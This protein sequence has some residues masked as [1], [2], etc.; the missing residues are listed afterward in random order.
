MDIILKDIEQKLKNTLH[1]SG[2]MFHI[3]SRVKSL[4]STTNKLER[5]KEVYKKEGKKMQDYLALRITLYFNDDIE[6]IHKYLKN[7]ANFVDESIDITE[8]DKFCPKRLNII[9]RIPEEHINAVNILL[10]QKGYKDMID[11]TYEVQIRTI[12]SEGWHE[13]EH[14]L[15][16]KCQED[17]NNFQEE[18]RLLNG[19]YA[20]L[21]SAEWSMLNLFDRLAYSHYKTGNWNCMLRNKMRIRF[22]DKSLSKEI[23]KFLDTN[24]E[25]AKELFRVDR[26]KVLRIIMEKR[27]SFPLTYDTIVQLLNHFSINNKELISLSEDVLREEIK[28]LSE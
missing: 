14:D 17:W 27:F 20:T 26:S 25:V 13:V 19:I 7:Q 18:S 8:V 21:E 3:F 24:K 5:K 22:A 4:E 9:L 28:L 6:I 23:I 15:R 2:L 1:K 10:S 12:L 11:D 16:Y